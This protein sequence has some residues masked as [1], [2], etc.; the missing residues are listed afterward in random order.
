MAGKWTDEEKTEIAKT[1]AVMAII[2]KSYGREIDV[3][4]TVKAWEFVMSDCAANQ[5]ISAMQAYMR[6]SNDIPSPADLIKIINPPQAKITYAEYKH[7]IEQH[8]L[9]GF[10]M[11]GYYGQVIKGYEKQQ[12]MEADTPSYYEILER[13]EKWVLENKSTGKELVKYDD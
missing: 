7:A 10:P 13:R 5:V 4:S 2:Q 1:L 12:A 11:C 3:K 8:A 9:E 6:Q